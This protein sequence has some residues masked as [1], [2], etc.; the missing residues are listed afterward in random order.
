MK[1]DYLKARIGE[2][3]TQLGLINIGIMAGQLLFPQYTLV[4]Q[5]LGALVNGGYAATPTKPRLG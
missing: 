4:W 3:D 2:R 5:G 1:F